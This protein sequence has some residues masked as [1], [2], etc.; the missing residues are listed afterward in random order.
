MLRSIRT[1]SGRCS[2]DDGERR[3]TV[4]RPRPTTSMS[5]VRP[6][7]KRSPSRNIGWS[8]TTTT[9]I[10]AVIAATSAP[11]RS[12]GR[13]AVTTVPSPAGPHLDRCR[14][15]PR[16][17]RASTRARRPRRSSSKPTPRSATSRH[18]ASGPTADH[19]RRRDRRRRGR[20]RCR[21]PA[22]RCGTPPPRPP[23]AS[24][25]A[26]S[27]SGRERDAD[28]GGVRV[29]APR[30]A[31]AGPAR[32]GAARA[33]AAGGRR[34]RRAPPPRA[35]AAAPPPPSRRAARRAASP[36]AS[37]S[38]ARVGPRLSC[39]SRPTRRRSSSR[40]STSRC[41]LARRVSA[42]LT[43]R[44]TIPPCRPSERS[45]V[46]VVGVPAA[47]RVG[48]DQ[49]LAQHVG[50]GQQRRPVLVGPRRQP[51]PVAPGASPAVTRT[52][53]TRS[54]VATDAAISATAS[55]LVARWWVDSASLVRAACGSSRS[56]Y[57]RRCTRRWSRPRSGSRSRASD[58]GDGAR[59]PGRQVAH[60][61]AIAAA[62][63]D[64]GAR[65]QDGEHDEHHGVVDDVVDLA[66]RPE[67]G[68]DDDHDEQE[69]G[70]DVQGAGAP[71]ARPGARRPGGS[72]TRRRRGAARPVA[73]AR[74]A[75]ARSSR[76]P[77]ASGISSIGQ[78][79]D[80]QVEP[81]E[82]LLPGGGQHTYRVGQADEPGG[83]GGVRVRRRPV[84]QAEARDHGDLCS[85]DHR[86]APDAR[87]GT[88]ARPSGSS[89]TASRAHGTR[90]AGT[91]S[92]NQTAQAAPGGSGADLDE[93][94]L[95]EPER[96]RRTGPPP[97]SASRRPG[98]GA[99]R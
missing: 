81:G 52:Y 10:D 69:A 20:R 30:P 16:P 85:D 29:P 41:R 36:A 89:T 96:R 84:D 66:P 90:N 15:A 27:S 59:T 19:Q 45:R 50:P 22:G 91:R 32:S 28:V 75:R 94:G 43:A 97:A 56:P 70:E 39:R 13:W 87:P 72:R 61:E 76:C 48:R 44:T 38:T 47:R 57:T 88:A 98:A 51:T 2:A 37:R 23:P 42:R 3:G 35:A 64:V 9:R 71:T 7:L 26:R 17:A 95:G 54:A 33:P 4:R 74:P 21:A 40:V 73:A 79:E 63:G 78:L 83:H 8:S 93:P 25:A 12:S 99:R 68:P 6:R 46:V 49:H 53:G 58:G 60:R 14:R 18:S 31:R 77:S 86:R 24:A 82:R 55:S 1:T 67:H 34:A 80:E 11:V 5:S 65:D 92:T 62:A